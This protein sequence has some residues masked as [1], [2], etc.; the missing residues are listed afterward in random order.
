MSRVQFIVDGQPVYDGEI[1]GFAPPPASQIEADVRAQL[2]P[3][4]R[5]SPMM[6]RFAI[7]SL[8][9]NIERMLQSPRLAPLTVQLDGWADGFTLKAQIPP[10]GDEQIALPEVINAEVVDAHE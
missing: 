6:K 1:P 8:A 5:M 10:M 4:Y 7:A 3:N 2:N 9:K